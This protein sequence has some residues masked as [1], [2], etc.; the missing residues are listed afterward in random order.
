[1]LSD[2][3]PGLSKVKEWQNMSSLTQMLKEP[4]V[5]S[6]LGQRMTPHPMKGW[7]RG[8]GGGGGGG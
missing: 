7:E 8:G 6:D 4:S 1:M 5:I 2:I 3:L